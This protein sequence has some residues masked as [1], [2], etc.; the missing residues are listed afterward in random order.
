MSDV[1]LD[2]FRERLKVNHIAV[3][4]T[5][6]SKASPYTQDIPYSARQAYL[7]EIRS[8]IYEDF[9]GLDVHAVAAGATNDHIDAAYQ[10][11]DEEADAFEYQLIEFIQQI[12]KLLGIEDTPVFKRNRISNQSEQTQMVL[13]AS[14]YLDEETILRKLPF[15]TVDEI[16]SILARKDV[17]NAETFTQDEAPTIP[18]ETELM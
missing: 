12:L 7:T 9:G 16:T 1:E 6:N 18:E 8:G 4:D 5:D 10:P 2:R 13:S 15:V 17:E 3:V 11:L 14:D